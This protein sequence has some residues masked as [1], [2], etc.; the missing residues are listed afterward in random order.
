MNI[1]IV[2]VIQNYSI[3]CY[4][5]NCNQGTK[6][7]QIIFSSFALFSYFI[8]KFRKWPLYEKSN[9]FKLSKVITSFTLRT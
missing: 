9:Y 7:I 6:T 3:K 8:T 1:F 5:F 2:L 4:G